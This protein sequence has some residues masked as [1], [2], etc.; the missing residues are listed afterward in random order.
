MSRLNTAFVTGAGGFIGKVLVR[1]LVNEGVTV[2]ALVVPQESVPAEWEGKVRTV[3]GDVR[4]LLAVADEVGRVDAIFHLAAIV[5]DWGGQQEHVDITVKGTEQAIELAL[6]WQAHFIVTT[7]VATFAS[8]L[9]QGRLKEDSPVGKPSSAYEFCKQEQERVT[10]AG[11][12]RGL[13][14]TIVRPGNVFGVGGHHW[15]T[16]M[17]DMMREQK[18]CQIGDGEF[19]AGLVHVSNLVSLLIAAARSDWTSGDIFLA[20]DGFG[21]TWKTYLERL[22]AA[23]G[24]PGPKSVPVWLARILAPVLE[25]AGH[26]LKQKERPMMTRQAFRLTGGSNEFSTDKSKKLLGYTPV[27]SFEQAMQELAENFRTRR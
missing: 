18:A 2:V 14:A 25:W 3:V 8:K 12:A 27:T 13:K 19:D 6:L 15:V 26:V 16:M 17:V 10:L 20:A 21:V 5:S 7:S 1:Q 22:A 23:A 11:V 4:N 9:G 24:T